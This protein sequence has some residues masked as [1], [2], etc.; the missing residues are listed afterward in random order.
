MN[1]EIHE[2]GA[3]RIAE[4]SAENLLITNAEDGLQLLVDLYYQDFDKIIIHQANITPTFFDLSTGLAGEI[5]Q[6]FSN[7]RVQLVN[8]GEF[9]EYPGK[10]IQQFIAESNRGNRINFLATVDEAKEK[11]FIA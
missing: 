8:I 3:T 11:L 5:L 2:Q 10:S 9:A 6:K 1:I 4:V 7:F